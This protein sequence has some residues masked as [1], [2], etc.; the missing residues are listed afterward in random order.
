MGHFRLKIAKLRPVAHITKHFLVLDIG[1]SFNV[2]G[3][4]SPCTIKMKIL[5][6]QLWELKVDWDEEASH[7]VH[8][9]WLKWCSEVEMLS[10]KHVF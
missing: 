4:F 10:T 3:W 6:Q 1:R 7:S 8:E 9:S 5:F 2:L